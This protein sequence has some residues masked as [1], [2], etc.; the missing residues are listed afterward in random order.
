MVRKESGASAIAIIVMVMIGVFFVLLG[1]KVVPVMTEFLGV[2]KMIRQLVE[3]FPNGTPREIQDAFA[4]KL[5]IEYVSS[6]S[7]GDLV[8]SKESG[9]VAIGATYDKPVRLFGED[10]GTHVDLNFHFEIQEGKKPM[11]AGK[12][13][14]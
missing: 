10:T 8:I 13:Q 7:P 14:D 12:V 4:R 11:A 3:E 9:T 5:A 6:I 1:F 2:K